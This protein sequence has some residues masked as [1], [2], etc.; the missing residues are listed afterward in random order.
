M[1]GRQTRRCAPDDEYASAMRHWSRYPDDLDAK[2][3]CSLL[4]RHRYH[5]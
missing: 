1:L 3:F 2:H 5:W 4:N